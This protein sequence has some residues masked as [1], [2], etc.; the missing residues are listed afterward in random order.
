MVI[1]AMGAFR[2]TPG[3]YLIDVFLNLIETSPAK[4]A[5]R[6][7][8][9]Q[10]KTIQVVWLLGY[11]KILGNKMA[12]EQAK[13]ATRGNTSPLSK[14]PTSPRRQGRLLP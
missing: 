1:R 11:R 3:H 2:S 7:R 13:K 10:R 5:R 9:K 4:Q 12:N 6:C 14:L 8:E